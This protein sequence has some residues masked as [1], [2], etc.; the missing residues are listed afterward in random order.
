MQ[1]ERTSPRLALTPKNHTASKALRRMD[2][3]SLELGMTSDAN[4][5]Q[6]TYN[7]AVLS[8]FVPNGRRLAAA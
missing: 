2:V 4:T 8:A 5:R 1:P 6:E 3:I 7:L